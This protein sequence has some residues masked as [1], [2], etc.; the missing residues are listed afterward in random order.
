MSPNVNNARGKNGHV[1][2]LRITKSNYQITTCL[3]NNLQIAVRVVVWEK[4]KILQCYCP[5]QPCFRIPE[6]VMKNTPHIQFS[7]TK[8]FKYEII[9]CDKYVIQENIKDDVSIF[10]TYN[11]LRV[12]SKFNCNI[13]YWERTFKKLYRQEQLI[14]DPLLFWATFKCIPGHGV[15]RRFNLSNVQLS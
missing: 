10:V 15:I 8:F 2:K 14:F 11:K 13:Y 4:C 6:H 1:C 12:H 3:T 5:H 9:R 7:Y